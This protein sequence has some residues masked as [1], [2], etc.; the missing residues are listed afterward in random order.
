M[1]LDGQVSGPKTYSEAT[2]QSI[3]QEA[4]NIVER[5]YQRARQLL[6][7][8][9]DKLELL[10]QHLLKHEVIEQATLATL[11]HDLNPGKEPQLVDS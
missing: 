10:A 4:Q 6:T 3:D 2:A 7:D 11:L 5:M 9:R 8:Q 1:F